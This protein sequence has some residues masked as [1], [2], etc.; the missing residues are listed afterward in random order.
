MNTESIYHYST[1]TIFSEHALG[2]WVL[3]FNISFKT[4]SEHFKN[5]HTQKAWV[6]CQGLPGEFYFI[7]VYL[8][9]RGRGTEATVILASFSVW[10]D[11]YSWLCIYSTARAIFGCIFVDIR[12]SMFVWVYYLW[13]SGRHQVSDSINYEL[14]R[15]ALANFLQQH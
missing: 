9:F 14:M 6:K 10:T 8:N 1:V 13:G 5:C 3:D 11:W 12:I 2:Q 4:N 15:L 7:F